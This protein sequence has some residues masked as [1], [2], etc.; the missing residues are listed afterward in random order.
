MKDLLKTYLTPLKVFIANA[1]RDGFR[2]LQ[3]ML[4]R[5]DKSIMFV[6]S[7]LLVILSMQHN[8]A[9]SAQEVPLLEHATCGIQAA[10]AIV[11]AR[12]PAVSAIAQEATRDN[13][14]KTVQTETFSIHLPQTNPFVPLAQVLSGVM[15]WKLAGDTAYASLKKGLSTGTLL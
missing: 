6:W 7:V 12:A 1:K 3:T 15:Y 9:N 10:L 11:M 4:A 14:A 13:R 2:P 5:V 8:N